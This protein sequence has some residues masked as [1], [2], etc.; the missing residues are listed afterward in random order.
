MKRNIITA[1]M[2]GCIFLSAELKAQKIEAYA[3]ID[4]IGVSFGYKTPSTSLPCDTSYSCY[5]PLIISIGFETMNNSNKDYFLFGSNTIGYFMNDNTL[6]AENGAMGE[7][8]LVNENDSILLFSRK[9][10]REMF[11]DKSYCTASINYIYENNTFTDFLCKFI[12]K[13]EFNSLLKIFNYLKRSK[14]IYVPYPKDY[15][16][17]IQ[18]HYLRKK[19]KIGYPENV[20]VMEMP[21]PLYIVFGKLD[22][23]SEIEIFDGKNIMR[24]NAL[25]L[26]VD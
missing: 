5:N 21:N 19:D 7:F 9:Y 23:N 25:Y 1:V 13:N 16:N 18:K 6:Y 24:N 20:I 4:F 15:E 2:L 22:N 26:K 14:V 8:F 10:G 17:I 11:T 3:K 12:D